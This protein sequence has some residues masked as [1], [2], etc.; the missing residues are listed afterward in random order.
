RRQRHLPHHV[1]ER[2]LGRRTVRWSLGR[3]RGWERERLRRGCGQQPR[4]EVWLYVFLDNH[5]LLLLN[6]HFANDH[7]D[8]NLQHDHVLHEYDR[9]YSAHHDHDLVHDEQ[10]D[11]FNDHLDDDIDDHDL[12]NGANMWH[13]PA[14]VGRSLGHGQRTVQQPLRCSNRWERERLRRRHGQQ[15]HP[16]VRRER[17]LSHHVGQ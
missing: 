13:V 14:E 11:D 9:H 7:D 5:N 2:R 6:D 12:H 17:H 16:E 8:Y 10:Y 3:R 4:P 1:G 15:P